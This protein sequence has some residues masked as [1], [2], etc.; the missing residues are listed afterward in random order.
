MT[1]G[2]IF[3][4]K[5]AKNLNCGVETKTQMTLTGSVVG[6]ERQ[7]LRNDGV[8][9]CSYDDIGDYV[10]GQ[11]QAAPQHLHEH[12]RRESHRLGCGAQEAAE[13]KGKHDTDEDDEE[14][15]Q[16]GD[17][18]GAGGAGVAAVADAVGDDVDDDDECSSAQRHAHEG[19]PG[20]NRG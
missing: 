9:D 20:W 8:I 16:G 10:F 15:V 17:G 19:Q 13:T 12:G 2:D 18:R 14:G 5:P 3:N 11:Q 4:S 6:K 1:R 7:A